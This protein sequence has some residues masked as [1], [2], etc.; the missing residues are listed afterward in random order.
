MTARRLVGPG[1]PRGLRALAARD[2]NRSHLLDYFF[3]GA[4]TG[5]TTGLGRVSHAPSNENSCL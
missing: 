5:F 4:T 2:R 1:P 3:T